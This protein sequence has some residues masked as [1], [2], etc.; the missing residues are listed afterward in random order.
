MLRIKEKEMTINSFANVKIGK[1]LTLASVISSVLLAC[2]AGLALWAVND[3]HA[4]A[5]KAERYAYKL[6]QVEKI[7]A[8]T[9]DIALVVRNLPSSKQVSRDVERILTGRKDYK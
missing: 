5:E 6:N 9:L 4:A 7:R 8:R 3:A 2:V 1:K